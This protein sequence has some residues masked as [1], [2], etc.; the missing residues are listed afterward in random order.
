MIKIDKQRPLIA[1]FVLLVSFVYGLPHLLMGFKLGSDYNP[2]VLSADSPTSSDEAWAYAPLV[3]HILKGNLHLNE[4]YVYEYRNS[5]TPFLGETASALVFALLSKV[6]GS[7][8][9]AF[10]AGDFIFPPII[11]L[12]FYFFIKSFVK[13]N[14]YSLA[15][16]FFA[17]VFRDFISV[18]PY[19][20]AIFD[21]LAFSNTN[22][23][24]FFSRAFHPQ[25]TFI[26]L[27]SALL[28]L[29]SVLKDPTNKLK[30][31]A[32]G[33][34]FG[35]LFYSYL[36]YWTYFLFFYIILTSYYLLTRQTKIVM[37]LI[38]AGLIAL[39][40]S[41]PYVINFIHFRQ[42]VYAQ[43]F[44]YKS[45]N[46]LGQFPLAGLRYALIP[47]FIFIFIKK[48]DYKF[49]LLI[50]FLAT[51]IIMPAITRLVL[52]RDLET[53][54]YTRRALMPFAT[55]AIFIIAYYLISRKELILRIVVTIMLILSTFIALGTQ[56]SVTDKVQSV[57]KV[58]PAQNQLFQWLLVNTPNDSV[59]ASL[60]QILNESIPIYTYNKVYYPPGVRT[61]MPTNEELDRYVIISSLLGIKPVIQK[62]N[63]DYNLQYIFYFQTYHPHGQG[64]ELDLKSTKRTLSE[65]RIDQL[66][67]DGWTKILPKYKLD[68]IIVSP[69]QI[70]AINPNLKF[71]TP[72]ATIAGNIVFR[73]NN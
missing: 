41:L 27:F 69:S 19:P 22:Y 23:F 59:V 52:G 61:I 1:I 73:I 14:V 50:I 5:P 72:I 55:V 47:I 64:Y 7:I 10:I 70:P 68:Y 65:N 46:Q 29:L 63:L 45:T 28:L 60:D 51:G 26:F 62:K 21:Y 4:I 36:F 13:N 48:K 32:F 15:T 39:V 16:A 17:V 24:L 42:A 54:H 38:F 3:N 9:N 30:I 2:L 66:A 33:V 8:P 58:N 34:S 67:G 40:L 43:D 35:V 31:L 44:I 71:I 25:L 11:F 37:T 20:R 57:Q 6:T 12:M 53:L 56:I 49:N 18:I